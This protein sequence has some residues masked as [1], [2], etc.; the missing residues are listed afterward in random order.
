MKNVLI[1]IFCLLSLTVRPQKTEMLKK[2][3]DTATSPVVKINILDNLIYQITQS[4]TDSALMYGRLAIS[5]IDKN[6]LEES[7]GTILS[8]IA[9]VYQKRSNYKKADSLFEISIQLLKKYND[10]SVLAGAYNNYGLSKSDQHNYKTAIKYYLKAAHLADSLKESDLAIN[11]FVNIGIIYY[12]QGNVRKALDYHIKALKMF[13]KYDR[14]QIGSYATTLRNIGGFYSILKNPDSALHYTQQSLEVSKEINDRRGISVAYQNLGEII[15]PKDLKKG[16]QYLKKS[17]Q[18]KKELKNLRGISYASVNLAQLYVRLE[19]YEKAVNYYKQAIKYAEKINDIK[20]LSYSYELL[21]GC[22]EAIGKTDKALETYKMHHAY[23]D[24]LQ[25]KTNE[26]KLLDIQTQYETAEKEKEILELKHKQK[27]NEITIRNS[28]IVAGITL[29]GILIIVVLLVFVLRT[30]KKVRERNDLLHKKNSTIEQQK[31]EI[32]VQRDHLAEKNEFIELQNKQIGD[33]IVYARQIQ[34]S[35]LPGKT[36]MDRSLQ[37]YFIFYRP[38]DVVSGDFYWAHQQ[39]DKTY[40]AVGDCTGHG[41]PGAFMSVLSISLLNEIVKGANIS[42]PAEILNAMRELIISSLK[43]RGENMRGKDGLELGLCVIDHVNRKLSFS[44]AKRP[45]IRV[46]QNELQ[47]FKP[48]KMPLS[49]Y[50][51]MQPF[52]QQEIEY[53]DGDL[54]Y[55]FSDGFQDQFHG[56]TNK[57]YTKNRFFELLKKA[58]ALNMQDQE[59]LL[60]NE[61]MQWKQ[62]EEQIDDVIVLGFKSDF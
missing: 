34:E 8:K 26:D 23:N 31:E 43:Q 33:S 7:R 13:E 61:F 15:A 2:Q 51:N 55:M 5:L 58:S 6:N 1:L 29:V 40:I 52:T 32:L 49:A 9:I 48:N 46:T 57:K 22:Y 19:E 10:F 25:E 11:P 53:Q 14:T 59:K 30:N 37:N 17:L 16:E 39:N 3:L 38:K 56:S 42:T 27:L 21:S 24:S 18:L 4:S 28:R 62:S 20:Q 35:L 44:G 54:F 50:I 12:Y 36:M 41:V 47:E 45:L 60:E